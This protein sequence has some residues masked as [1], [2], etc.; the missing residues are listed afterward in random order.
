[1][2]QSIFQ[3]DGSVCVDDDHIQVLY[4]ENL[5]TSLSKTDYQLQAP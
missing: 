3:H 5:F 2:L 4:L 1:M